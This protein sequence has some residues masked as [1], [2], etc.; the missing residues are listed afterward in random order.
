MISEASAHDSPSKHQ[1][2]GSEIQHEDIERAEAAMWKT[3]GLESG[4]PLET[5]AESLKKRIKELP[6]YKE[7]EGKVKG[8]PPEE[9]FHEVF[10]AIAKTSDVENDVVNVPT[11]GVL[12]TSMQ[13]GP[14]ECA[15]RVLIA[16][17]FLQEKQIHH[18]VAT[19]PGHV[20]MIHEIDDDTVAYADPN[21]DLYFTFP[22]KA[23]LGYDDGMEVAE[24]KIETY[25]P[26]AKDVVEGDGSAFTHFLVLSPERGLLH[27]YLNN[28]HAALSGNDEFKSSQVDKDAKAAV[29]IDGI[30]KRIFAHSNPILDSWNDRM[31]DLEK[32]ESG[33][34]D[35]SR[36]AFIEILKN[37]PD[38][39]TFTEKIIDLLSSQFG[40]RYPYL[41]NAPLENKI[42]WSK[43]MWDRVQQNKEFLGGA[44]GNE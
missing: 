5:F 26:R 32:S 19:P 8:V 30:E 43:R 2:Q 28:V 33:I 44:L 15:G 40:K 36:K 10:K 20:M 42:A 25:L 37:A 22:K 3:L 13:H 27:S 4:K 17:I 41:H 11:D 16:S 23:L 14:L 34:I 21:N 12:L 38:E 6:R 39:D 35:S 1:E 31:A 9:L 29:A 18:S 24:C 7:L